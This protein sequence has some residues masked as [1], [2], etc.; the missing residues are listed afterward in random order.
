MTERKT[1]RLISPKTVLGKE[2]EKYIAGD[3]FNLIMEMAGKESRNTNFS[4]EDLTGAVYEDWNFKKSNFENCKL[5]NAKFINCN[6]RECNFNGATIKNSTF[7]RSNM[8][9][10]TF[11]DC[12][13]SGSSFKFGRLNNC[14]IKS[15]FTNCDL[16][17]TVST[18][19]KFNSTKFD[20]CNLVGS[21]IDITMGSE[22]DSSRIISFVD[23]DLSSSTLKG[24]NDVSTHIK[25]GNSKMIG[26]E[27]ADLIVHKDTMEGTDFTKSDISS[28]TF[29]RCSLEDVNFSRA[30]ISNTLFHKCSLIK[31][32]FKYG[33]IKGLV[34][35]NST[36][37]NVQ[38]GRLSDESSLSLKSSS[39]IGSHIW[40]TEE[41]D[42]VMSEDSKLINCKINVVSGY[43]KATQPTLEGCLFTGS[44]LE[45]DLENGSVKKCDFTKMIFSVFKVS[46][47][48]FENN[49]FSASS[50]SDSQ[51]SG[52]SLIGNSF[53]DVKFKKSALI[54]S[55]FKNNEFS[56]T[57]FSGSS[58]SFSSLIG[59][60]FND[61]EFKES[62]MVGNKYKDIDINNVV[63]DRKSLDDVSKEI[64]F[65]EEFPVTIR[66]KS[67][68]RKSASSS[69]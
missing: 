14:S 60:S 4:G 48:K 12:E 3:T 15:N 59:G 6:L 27:L 2:N 34:F 53:N 67:K 1:S 47:I 11:I 23:S 35:D 29:S 25:L 69:G 32:M 62:I 30:K 68:S 51:I 19:S 54:R 24:T 52:S 8:G 42:L 5:I 55:E 26:A 37:E 39:L 61:V 7:E 20:K 33:T 31:S 56:A 64:F 63:G 21:V 9:S 45:F 18:G 16:S 46:D 17:N 58:I 41:L 57:S 50:F 38:F 43:L 44:A 36:A 66:A 13:V 65:P 49:K 28:C 40:W 10:S 22:D